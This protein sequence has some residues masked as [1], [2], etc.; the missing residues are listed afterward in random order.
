MWRVV[1]RLLPL[2]LM[3]VTWSTPSFGEQGMAIDPATCMGCHN[4]K[5]SVKDFAAS[6]HGKN[7]CTSCHV[8]ITD[9]V[10]HM[11]RTVKVQKVSCER[12]HKKETSEH[13]ASIHAEKDVACASCHTDIHTHNYWKNDKR[14][15]I[16]KC[17]QC[18]DKEKVFR[19]RCMARL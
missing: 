4:T 17:I 16:A 9:L 5:F 12:C 7:A 8:D 11:T 13:Y 18:H 19:I 3:L 10:K 14:K 2:L 15:V 1:S 6:V